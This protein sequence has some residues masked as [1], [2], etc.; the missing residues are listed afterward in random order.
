MLLGIAAATAIGWTV[1]REL[2]RELLRQRAVQAIER[3]ERG[4]V[5]HLAQAERDVRALATV[6]ENRYLDP[7]ADEALDALLR[8]LLLSH[9]ELTGIGVATPDRRVRA[10]LR[11]PNGA[12]ESHRE[13]PGFGRDPQ[14]EARLER[15][16]AAQGT[17][18]VEPIYGGRL[19]EAV[20]MA[21]HPIRRDGLLVAV[22]SA[23]ITVGKLSELVAELAGNGETRPFVLLGRDRV[24]AHPLLRLVPTATR[25]E[26]LVPLDRF[27]DRSLAAI[28]GGE[29]VSA[30]ETTT[31]A[32]VRAVRVDRPDDRAELVLF[33]EIAG[34]GGVPWTIGLVVPEILVHPLFL[35]MRVFLVA[36]A[37][38]AVAAVVLAAAV[39]R[40]LARPVAR[41]TAAVERVSTL[42]LAALEPLPPSRLRE[43]DALARAFN[44]MLATLKAFGTYVPKSLVERLVRSGRPDAVPSRERDLA[45]M[46]TDIQGFTAIAETLPPAEVARLLNAHFTILARCVEEEGGTVDKYLG[47]GML[48]FWGAPE[49]IKNRA[50]RACRAALAIRRAIEADNALKRAR[51]EPVFRLRI[52]IHRGPLVVGNIGAPGKVNYTVVGDTVNVA[53][54]LMEL[55]R[56]RLDE[57]KD[58]AIV[59][60][61]E[62]AEEIRTGFRFADIGILA[63]RGREQPVRAFELLGERPFVVF[64]GTVRAAA[65]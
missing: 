13:V 12:L 25:R 36:A 47:D 19:G 42:E 21:L 31:D 44:A 7:D 29:P 11:R 10:L 49:K 48:A 15:A 54:R 6:L 40:A 53:Q 37:A 39:G 56:D 28:A 4:L 2:T 20:L 5:E 32:R 61:R 65:E 52:G 57:T 35:P 8:G 27:A 59:T 60:S 41:V 30:F 38:I 51:G 9:E 46:F 64:D 14:L 45:V 23:G 17:V 62:V 16:A 34:F 26:P 55:A 18:W 50:L 63:P 3:L 22:V 24:L 33:K 43:L 1:A 58:V